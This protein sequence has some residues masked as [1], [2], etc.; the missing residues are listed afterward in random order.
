MPSSSDY[1]DTGKCQNKGNSNIKC[2]NKAVGT[3]IQNSFSAPRHRF[4][5]CLEFYWRDV[6]PFF[7]EKFHN[8]VFLLMA[9]ENAVSAVAPESPISVRLG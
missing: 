8:L 9:E 6:T 3:T 4:Y 1:I 2:L 7:H 5:K